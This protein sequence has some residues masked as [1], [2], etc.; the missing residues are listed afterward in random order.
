MRRTAVGTVTL[1]VLAMIL[2][3]APTARA[4]GGPGNPRAIASAAWTSPGYWVAGADGGVTAHG[5]AGF[6]G[7]TAGVRLSRPVVG[8]ASTLSG[9]GYR[10]VASDGGIF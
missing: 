5:A 3:F 6:Y 10:L 9:R 8:M 1:A 4:G 7:S 2:T